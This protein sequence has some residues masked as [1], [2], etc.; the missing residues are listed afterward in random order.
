[1]MLWPMIAAATEPLTTN[2]AFPWNDLIGASAL[3]VL[4]CG[5]VIAEIFTASMGL[6]ALAAAGCAVSAIILAFDI[7]TPI[8]W[9]FLIIVPLA[10]TG[11]LRW[12]L[13]RLQASRLVPKDTISAE[14]G[15][16]HTTD[17]LGITIGSSGELVTAAVPS[18]R[19]RFA[20]GEVDVTVIG[21]AGA[22][23]QRVTVLR[24][25]GA[26]VTVAVDAQ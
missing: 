24:I 14:V 18:G 1:M 16:H 23:G 10:I 11:L 25:E 12:G 7:S 22:R 19:A 21:A 20:N 4:A 13:A 5:L 2:V 8:G 17:A 9:A 3:A 6:L 26:T 15:I